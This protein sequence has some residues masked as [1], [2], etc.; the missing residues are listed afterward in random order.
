MFIAP[1]E[2]NWT[3]LMAGIICAVVIT[4]LI[5]LGVWLLLRFHRKK[6]LE[7]TDVPIDEEDHI[8]S[9]RI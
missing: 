9:K 8:F 7:G 5:G 4:I 6:I 3:A 1:K 2:V